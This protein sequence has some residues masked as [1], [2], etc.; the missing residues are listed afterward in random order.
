M[1]HFAIDLG[2][3]KS[4]ICVRSSD[5]TL[6]EE[7]S[8]ATRKLGEL[9]K[10]RGR[11]R[12]VL[13]TCSEAFAVADAALLAGHEVRVV[14]ATL[15]RQL[16]VGERGLK[17]D[18][19]DAR[20]LSEV[21]CRIDLPSVHVPSLTSRRRKSLLGMRDLLVRNRTQASNAV[22][23]YLRGHLLQVAG[24]YSVFATRVREIHVT[25]IGAAVP[26]HIERT[27]QV[28]ESLSRQIA[29]A[30][31]EVEREAKADP[32]ARR[33]MTIPGVGPVTSLSFVAAIDDATRFSSGAQIASY[34]GLVPG[35]EQSSSKVRPRGITKAGSPSLRWRLIQ[36][37]WSCLRSRTETPLKTWALQVRE[38]RGV[39]IAVTALARKLS[40]VM[41]ALWR[42]GTEYRLP[43]V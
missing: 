4:Q 25:M 20:K 8:V 9:L 2:G 34:V 19:R 3:R 39:K 24:R 41:F 32:V 36:A 26:N 16:G 18:V 37:A 35:I 43:T 21:S 1:E 29:E 14:P 5:G 30:D 33:L 28:I 13:E 38:R 7:G 10:K 6:L 40:T 27:L 12:V 31:R 23:G 17:T 22:R 42:D 15:V 11:S